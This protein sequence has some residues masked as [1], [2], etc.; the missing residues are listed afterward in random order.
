MKPSIAVVGPGAIGG[1]VGAWLLRAG[2]EVTLCARTP[3]AE[4]VVETSGEILHATPPIWTEPEQAT[5]VD[6]VLVATKTY[7]VAGAAAWLDVLAGPDTKV[8][9]LQNGVEHVARFAPFVPVDRLLSVVVDIPAE[10][11]APGHIRQRRSGTMLVPPGETGR[12]FAELF[13]DTAITVT[14]TADFP[15]ALWR[16]L[17]INVAGA[18]SA[19]ADEGGGVAWRESAARLMRALVTECVTVGR[20][21]GAVLEDDLVEAVIEHYRHG[22]RDAINSLHADR[23]AGR[24]ME[25]DA[26]N[27]VIGRL[28]RQHG[29]ATPVSDAVS[30]LLAAIDERI[31]AA[32]SIPPAP[33]V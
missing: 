8:A 26:R 5:S 33:L 29:I 18:V 17:A 3:F 19:L 31:S 13:G 11:D 21:E 9:V 6:W 28:G 30:D 4:L 24:P 12:A 25:W 20:A 32:A 2:H 1:T 23:I 27:G 15:G 14:E 10:R 7:A 22:H 16:K